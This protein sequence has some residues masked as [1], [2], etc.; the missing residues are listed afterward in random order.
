MVTSRKEL[1][2]MGGLISEPWAYDDV[3]TPLNLLIIDILVAWE[4][5][6]VKSDFVLQTRKPRK[7]M[8]CFLKSS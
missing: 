5:K 8:A 4:L 6:T 1:S 7:E 2:R 3:Y